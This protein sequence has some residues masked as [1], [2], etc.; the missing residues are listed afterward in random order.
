MSSLQKFHRRTQPFVVN[1]LH[2][3]T[4]SITG[5]AQVGSVLS[6][7]STIADVD[8]LGTFAY[9]WKR[10]GTVISGATSSTYTLVSADAA[11]T[12][13]VTITYTDGKG[14]IETETSAATASVVV[15]LAIGDGNS[16]KGYYV[17]LA[18]DGVSK[19]FVAPAS[20]EWSGALW[21]N[22]SAASLIT[23]M[24]NSVSDGISNTNNLYGRGA[25][26]VAARN[27]KLLSTGGYSW[28][29]PAINELAT[30]MTVKSTINGIGQGMSGS[31]QYWFSSSEATNANA[32]NY[33]WGCNGG[34]GTSSTLY[35]IQG[36]YRTRAV[37]SAP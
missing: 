21:Q 13:T 26:F 1:T 22:V 34:N 4:V 19:M 17:G 30:I 27:C 28:Y 36:A 18:G 33:V 7:T 9:Q 16:T 5:V 10:S 32:K 11:N 8:G 25:A 3:G 23:T 35:K 15:P 6:V 14:F 20:T 12:I 24:A 29:M 37:R 31:G 2:T